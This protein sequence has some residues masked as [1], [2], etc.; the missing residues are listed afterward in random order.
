MN[1]DYFIQLYN[2]NTWANE[3]VWQCA[4]KTTQDHYLKD[5]TFSVGSVYDQLFH[6]MAVES[7]WI[8][9][10]ATGEVNFLGDDDSE[11]CQDRE[12]LRQTWDAINSK[13]MSYINALTEEELQRGVKVRWWADSAPLITVA[14]AL[15]QVA[16]HST[17][18]RAQTMALLHML[19]YDG[20]E[21]DFLAYL[22]H[23][24]N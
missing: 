7:W 24:L 11:K 2:Y 23:D 3:R 18:H 12:L 22:H 14:Q 10:L 6:T 5:S 19:G 20:T 9:F 16:N 13:N 8:G 17:D 1:K 21:Q 15:T 4:M